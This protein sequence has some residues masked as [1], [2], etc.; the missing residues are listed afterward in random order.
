MN[1][2]LAI[3][4]IAG[5]GLDWWSL[6]GFNKENVLNGELDNGPKLLLNPNI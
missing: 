2:Q 1:K 3:A 5:F 6:P 4:S